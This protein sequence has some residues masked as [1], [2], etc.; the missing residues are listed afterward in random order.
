MFWGLGCTLTH[1]NLRFCRVPI[2][3]ILGF[4]LRTYEKVGFG[5]L[6]CRV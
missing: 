2:K 4:I 3:S 1:Q 6:G 5:R